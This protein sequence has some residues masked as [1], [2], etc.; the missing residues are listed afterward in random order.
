MH[1]IQAVRVP[2][3]TASFLKNHFH[4]LSFLRVYRLNV[5]QNLHLSGVRF[6][7]F[8]CVCSSFEYF[9][10]VRCAFN[11]QGINDLTV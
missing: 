5:S 10:A 9:R 6:A 11:T 8:D 4:S 3:L 2:V 7:N 1:K